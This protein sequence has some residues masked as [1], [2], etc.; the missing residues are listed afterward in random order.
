MIGDKSVIRGQALTFV[1]S[2]TDEDLPATSP[3][4]T[5]DAASVGL[6]MTIATATGDFSW[7]PTEAPGRPT[8]MWSRSR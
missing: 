1:A 6:G 3:T 5:L 8:V 2:A 7:T 4:F